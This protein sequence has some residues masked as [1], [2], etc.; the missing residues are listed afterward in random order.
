MGLSISL[1]IPETHLHPIFQNIFGIL[2]EQGVPISEEFGKSTPEI[3]IKHFRNKVDAC[4]WAA[5]SASDNLIVCDDTHTLG[6]AMLA[7]GKAPV[8]TT[9]K[10]SLRPIEH[11]FSDGMALL[12]DADDIEVLRDYLSVSHHPLN[13][14]KKDDR[15][16]RYELLKHI[17]SVGGYGENKWTKLTFDSILEQYAN[18]NEL[19]RKDIR[20]FLPEANQPL[21]FKRIQAFCKSLSGWAEIYS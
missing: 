13:T 9:S 20:S 4:L 2:R 16:L 7:H 17:V 1:M 11:L 5:A 10:A 3:R 12:L 21:T 8:D 15:N 6:A 18:G 19:V 14:F